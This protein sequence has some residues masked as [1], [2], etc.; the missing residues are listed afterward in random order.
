MTGRSAPAR[1]RRAVRAILSGLD[2]PWIAEQ[3]ARQGRRRLFRRVLSSELAKQRRLV[4]P[5]SR[6]AT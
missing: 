2:N 4:R 1:A 5:G 6:G 3:F